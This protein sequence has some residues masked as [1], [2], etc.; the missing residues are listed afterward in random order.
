VWVQAVPSNRGAVFYLCR[1]SLNDPRFPK[2][3]VLPVLRCVA[4]EP[5]PAS[6]EN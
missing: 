5:P 3:P 1:Q 2:Y 6:E 4:F